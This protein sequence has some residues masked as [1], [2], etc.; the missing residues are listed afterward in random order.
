MPHISSLHR[1][2]TK[3]APSIL[4]VDPAPREIADLFY[5]AGFYIWARGTT[6]YDCIPFLKTTERILDRIGVD[7]NEKIRADILCL[8][9]LQLLGSGCLERRRGLDLLKDAWEIR[10]V[11]YNGDPQ[12][13]NDVLLQNAAIDYS[14][15]LLNEHEFRKAGS[16]IKQCRTRYLEWGPESKNPFEN[17]KYYAH[18]CVVLMVEGKMAEAVKLAETAVDLTLEFSKTENTA[19]YYERV[20]MLAC[21]LLQAGEY[22]KALDKH[23]EV[24]KA[25]MEMY[26]KLHEFTIQS[27]YAV[28]GMY[29][30]LGYLTTA[31]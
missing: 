18:Y 30:Q 23:L 31:T 16:I 3:M 6:A 17:S 14:I 5:D 8:I 11:I 22:Q 19:L 21:I 9:G 24:L 15:A 25:R 27:I 13:D 26:G 10:K 29:H 2:Y 12:Y 1:V 4:M 7:A 28:G 20:F